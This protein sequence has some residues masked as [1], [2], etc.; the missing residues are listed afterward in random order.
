MQFTNYFFF[1]CIEKVCEKYWE[2]K[3]G[4]VIIGGG[5]LTCGK[6]EKCNEAEHPTV[7]ECKP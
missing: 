7:D 4:N 6:G 2:C 1:S 3:D 5:T